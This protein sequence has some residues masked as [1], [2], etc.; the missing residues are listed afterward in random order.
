[1]SGLRNAGH[2]EEDPN[3]S[4]PLLILASCPVENRP[5]NTPRLWGKLRLRINPD[6]L[7]SRIYQSSTAEEAFTCN[8]E[9]NPVYR[10]ILEDSGLKVSGISEDGGARIIELPGHRFFLATGFVPQL[11]SEEKKPHPL[12]VAYLKAAA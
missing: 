4:I 1:V 6:T 5:E 12:V 10:G 11:V 9:L 3:A 8:Y 2:T 7:A